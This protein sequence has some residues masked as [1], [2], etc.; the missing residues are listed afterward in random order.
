MCVP[1]VS[2]GEITILVSHAYFSYYCKQDV[3]ESRLFVQVL[4][5]FGAESD[6]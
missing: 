1:S 3:V 2:A 6:H 4:V 5:N